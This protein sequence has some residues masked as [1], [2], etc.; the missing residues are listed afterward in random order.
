MPLVVVTDIKL[1][2]I[3][4]FHSSRDGKSKTT[5]NNSPRDALQWLLLPLVICIF[6]CNRSQSQAEEPPAITPQLE[7]GSCPERHRFV[8]RKKHS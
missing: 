3:L 8:P 6:P 2:L 1:Q 5:E 7:L 4:P